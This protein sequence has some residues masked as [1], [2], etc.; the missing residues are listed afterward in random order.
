MA[1]KPR[2]TKKGE[3]A[4]DIHFVLTE[5]ARIQEQID[6]DPRKWLKTAPRDDIFVSLKM[7]DG[8]GDLF[9]GADAYRRLRGLS[10]RTLQASDAARTV[11]S[12]KVFTAL[13]EIVLQRFVVEKRP[14]NERQV[15]KALAEAVRRAKT[16]RVDRIHFIPCR[17]MYAKKPSEFTIGAV[18]FRT[19]ESFVEVMGPDYQAY[20][21]EASLTRHP[22]YLK[23][24]KEYYGAFG[25]VA[26]V[27]IKSCDYE[28]SRERAMMAVTAAVDML[29]VIFGAYHTRRMFV[30]GPSTPEDDRAHMSR[31]RKS[32]LHISISQSAT[33]AVGFQDGWGEFLKRSD[34]S[35]LMEAA[36]KVIEPIADP[37]VNRPLGLRISDAAAWFG[38]AV[39][40]EAAASRIVKAVTALERLVMTDGDNDKSDTLSQRCAAMLYDYGGD[41]DFDENV[42]KLKKAY[43]L[44]S[45]LVHGSLSPFDP[46][47]RQGVHACLDICERV[48]CAGLAFFHGNGLFERAISNNKLAVGFGKLVEA[49]KSAKA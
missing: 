41:L 49:V 44:R 12:D 11:E 38:L 48:L 31:T 5:A 20:L 24:A 33:A 26:E 13:R 36:A 21:A 1:T 16:V 9:C 10:D 17:L 18:T 46:D 3:A 39:R 37:A 35:Y 45:R 19:K 42:V 34:I 6:A 29:H 30:G 43:D 25:W 14:I 47:V 40:E 22:D 32:G 8:K 15:D 28:V 4:A 7:P 23:S 27:E 2:L